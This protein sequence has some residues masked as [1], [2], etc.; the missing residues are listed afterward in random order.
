MTSQSDG[1]FAM[2]VDDDQGTLYILPKAHQRLAIPASPAP[3]T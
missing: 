1:T 2:N 3:N